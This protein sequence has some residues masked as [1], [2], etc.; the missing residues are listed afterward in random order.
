M[1]R[2]LGSWVPRL[3]RAVYRDSC[4][5]GSSPA[6][7]AGGGCCPHCVLCLATEAPTEPSDP[8]LST[9]PASSEE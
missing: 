3:V 4:L 8:L 5:D 9:L 7:T 1:G 2:S 6:H